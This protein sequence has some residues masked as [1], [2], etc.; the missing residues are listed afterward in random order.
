[1]AG[2]VLTYSNSTNSFVPIGGAMAGVAE[3]E[4]AEQGAFAPAK[5]S[6]PGRQRR[7][8]KAWLATPPHPLQAL[9]V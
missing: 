3:D 4:D 8:G 5:D 9:A 2:T 7:E 6:V 1:M